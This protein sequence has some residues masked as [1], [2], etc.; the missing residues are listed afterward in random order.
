VALTTDTSWDF[1][2]SAGHTFDAADVEFVNVGGA[3]IARAKVGFSGNTVIVAPVTS[4]AGFGDIHELQLT[5]KEEVGYFHTFAFAF[6]VDGSGDP[7]WQ[8]IIGGEWRTLTILDASDLNAN[9]ADQVEILT[10]GLGRNELINN[11]FWLGG[12]VIYVAV[13]ISMV[14]GATQGQIDQISLLHGTTVTSILG[15]EGTLDLLPTLASGE[16]AEPELPIDREFLH[17]ANAARGSDGTTT[18]IADRTRIR[19]RYQELK[20]LLDS[21]ADR[22]LVKDFLEAHQQTPFEWSPPIVEAPRR[23]WADDVTEILIHPGA[24]FEISA[25]LVEQ[26]AGEFPDALGPLS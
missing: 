26:F 8:T 21:A 15:S 6:G 19:A 13:G 7:L 1:N 11:R 2:A 25:T 14:A 20:W 18:V 12:S 23:F 16:R 9:A 3:D 24:A 17:A 10:F 4:R 22:T 5:I